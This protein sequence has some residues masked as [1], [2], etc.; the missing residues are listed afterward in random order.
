M[1]WD[2]MQRIK[3][4]GV[5]LDTY[6]R[7]AGE[8]VVFIHGSMGDECAAVLNEPV[9]TEA[10]RLIHY[11]RRGWGNSDPLKPGFRIAEQAAD[12]LK[13]MHQLDVERAHVAGQSYGASIS[14][15]LALDAPEAV[16]SLAVMEPPLPIAFRKVP[17][18]RQMLS[19]TTALYESGE[20]E[21]AVDVFAQE[22]VGANYRAAFDDTLPDGSVERWLSA[23]DTLFGEA[24]ALQ[25]WT[26]SR[27]DA[28]QISQPVLN[29]SGEHTVPFLRETYETLQAWLPQAE[30]VVLPDANHAML[31]TNPEG[32]AEHLADFFSR[33]SMQGSY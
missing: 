30:H 14:L 1:I 23:A 33:H 16:H 18:A 10:Y 7:G 24:P 32:A 25:S 6:D 3:I 27:E 31:Q 22:V 21:R 5:E 19:E 2:E 29:M 13:V 15:Q 8:P 9:F 28:A 17:A 4:N 11:H 12:C 20:K 26:F